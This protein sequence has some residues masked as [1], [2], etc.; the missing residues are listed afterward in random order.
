[1]FTSGIR[2]ALFCVLV[3]VSVGKSVD[4]VAAA[5]ALDVG[6]RKQLFIDHKFI[7]SQQNISLRP[8][9]PEKLP[10]NILKCDKPWEAFTLTYFSVVQEEGLFRMWYQPWTE[11]IWGG[12]D[13][14]KVC[15]AESTDGRNWVKPNLGLVEFNGSKDT[16]ILIDGGQAARLAYVF[17]DT[18]P[19]A[20]N[21]DR[22]KMLWGYGKTS[23]RTSPDGIHW[24]DP[25]PVVWNYPYDTQKQ[26]WWDEELGKYVIHVRSQVSQDTSDPRALPFPF[27]DPI[28]SNPPVVAPRLHR[29]IRQLA[30]LE[31]DDIMQPWPVDSARTVFGG[32]EL[33]PPQ[34]DIYH[35]G[36][37]YK[38]PY[39]DDAYFMFPWVY[40][41]WP[42]SS[43]PNDGVI[44]AQFAA[45]RNGWNWMRYGREVYIPR[46]T[47]GEMDYGCAQPLGSF[48]RDGDS[49]YQFYSG[50]P[51]THGGFRTLTAQE[52]MDQANW[53]RKVYRLN[54]YRL[55]GFVSA[56]ASAEGGTL[57]TPT[58]MFD[59]Q[60]LF[61]NIEVLQGGS[62]RVAIVDG[63][64]SPLPGFT[65]DDCDVIQANDVAYEVRWNGDSDISGL[66][67]TPV[68]LLFEMSSTKLYAF[69]FMP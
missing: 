8:N 64:G 49:L 44:N 14:S 59:G 50:W 16:N 20:P 3:L 7:D 29:A 24:T 1:M 12:T 40:E 39:A 55:D 47:E 38:Y 27:V 48:F 22:Y 28:P 43:V 2:K 69:Q 32:D 35:P 19:D 51:W 36:G 63:D 46:G 37:V 15:Y 42:H 56:D 66:A 26:A 34:T 33:D 58:L 52:R 5:D 13:T 9:P 41:H 62:A 11:P 25:G 61:L 60:R 68:G 65:L 4:I 45:S 54:K 18:N 23:I 67:G 17:K 6:N 10:E 57:E 30:H 31:A 21:S 53:A